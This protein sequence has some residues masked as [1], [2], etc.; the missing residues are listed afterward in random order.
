MSL[1]RR[2]AKRDTTEKTIVKDLRKAGVQ[3]FL[4]SGR[5]LP[6]LLT[7]FRGR[8]LPLEVKRKGGRLT[9][10]QKNTRVLAPFPV[11]ENSDQAFKAIGL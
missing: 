1:T 2:N 3:V 11:V 6:D 9:D 10:A 5:G 8:W 7:H 4:V